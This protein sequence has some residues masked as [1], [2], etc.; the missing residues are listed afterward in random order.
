M[1]TVTVT[2]K[3]K[4]WIPGSSSASPADLL[5]GKRL[6]SIGFSSADMR[7]YGWTEVGEAEVTITLQDQQT[8]VANKIDSLREEA[9]AIRAEAAAK[10]TRI[11]GQIN[12]LLALSFDD[13]AG[14]A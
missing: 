11:E 2:T 1:T 7:E 13:K 3:T 4:A 12:D 14:A 9:K 6:D 8:M 5:A 10:V